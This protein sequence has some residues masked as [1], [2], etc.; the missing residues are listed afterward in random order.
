[1][2]STHFQGFSSHFHQ[3]HQR[4]HIAP[5]ASTAYTQPKTTP[6]SHQQVAFCARSDSLLLLSR[7]QF[8]R[9]VEDLWMNNTQLKFE[10]KIPMIQ[11]LLHSQEITQY[12]LVSRPI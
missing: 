11:K 2:F 8:F 4:H 5:T 3:R 6:K 10:G 7:S 1:M 9:I 12:F